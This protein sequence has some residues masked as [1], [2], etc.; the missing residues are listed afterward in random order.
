M[1]IVAATATIPGPL[2]RPP[3]LWTPRFARS[4]NP[5][6]HSLERSV[7]PSGSTLAL[8]RPRRIRSGG[9]DRMRRVVGRRLAGPS[10]FGVRIVAV[11]ATIPGPLPRLPV[12]WTPRSARSSNPVTVL[13][14]APFDPPGRHSLRHGRAGF[15]PAGLIGRGRRA[16]RSTLRVD[17][18]SGTAAPD[19]MMC[20][21]RSVRP[22]GS[23]LALARPC[24]RRWWVPTRRSARLPG[25]SCHESFVMRA[26]P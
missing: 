9:P 12:L 3:V 1:R 8:A 13:L 6:T 25:V 7:R 15:N 5:V 26:S 21:E 17:T 22:S 4:S 24:Q 23:T 18:R 11:T 14:S 16:L 10:A 19:S 20:L 2:P